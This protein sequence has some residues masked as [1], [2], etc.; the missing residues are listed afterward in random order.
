MKYLIIDAYPTVT[1]I[2][3]KYVGGYIFPEDLKLNQALSSN[4]RLW[5]TKYQNEHSN[6]FINTSIID[7]IDIEGVEI[8]RK[9]KNELI[10]VKIEYFSAGKMTREII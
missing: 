10:D 2:R 7:S 8:A 3:D 9:I 6:G 1:G 4:I 5:V